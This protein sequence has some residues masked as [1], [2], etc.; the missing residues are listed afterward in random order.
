MDKLT[1]KDIAK[2]AGVSTTVVS[3]V[4]N[5]KPGVNAETRR[6]VNEI[7]QKTNFKPS[8]SSR[9]LI[10]QKSFNI[11]I[12]ARKDS[13]PFNNLFYFEIAQGL[14]EKSEEFGYNVVFTKIS[15]ENGRII[16]PE[17]IEQKDTDGIIFLQDTELVILNEIEQ[18][19]IPYVV[20]DAHPYNDCFT[21]INA[22]YEQSAYTATMHLIENGHK[23]IAFICSSFVPN[24]YTQ[25][26]SG[27]KKALD[28]R[29]ISIPSS[30]IQIEA[31]DETSAFK[32]MEDILSR[33]NHPS[34]VFCA[35]DIYAIGAAKC[36]KAKGFQIPSAIS[37]AS[38]DDI[39]L[40]RYMEPALT[41]VRIDKIGM[42]TLA[43][44]LLVRK[45]NGELV[46]SLTVAS[47]N[48][49]VRDSV[50]VVER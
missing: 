4:I 23:D 20:V 41:T 18:R 1:I 46:E 37:F 6:K 48:L 33:G 45:I 34:A 29:D 5:N 38:I 22:N 24:F 42:G 7:L 44:E 43:M 28:N 12:V 8:M 31:I 3:F 47:D 16:L 35:A 9:R 49:I 36:A 25:V 27:F 21:S 17:I 10:Y 50:K 11:C 39:L 2:M 14:L 32:C 19:G 15:Q 40:A 30:W 13:S 26:F